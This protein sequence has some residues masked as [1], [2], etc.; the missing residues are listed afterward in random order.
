MKKLVIL[1]GVLLVLINSIIL[2]TVLNSRNSNIN[3]RILVPEPGMLWEDLLYYSEAEKAITDGMWVD[4]NAEMAV[5]IAQQLV[6]DGSDIDLRQPYYVVHDEENR[7]FIVLAEWVHGSSV[8][9][10][11]VCQD[12]GGILL[13][14]V[15]HR[16]GIPRMPDARP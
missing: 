1:F 9:R 14:S 3:Y 16:A 15:M 12:S 7:V 6:L 13:N 10:T 8:F 2:F 5:R 4:V 11:I